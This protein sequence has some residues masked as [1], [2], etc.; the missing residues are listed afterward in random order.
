M[1]ANHSDATAIFALPA[2]GASGTRNPSATANTIAETIEDQN[3][4]D[5]T[6][7]E[8]DE[9]PDR[10]DA[11]DVLTVLRFVLDDVYVAD[12]RCADMLSRRR[13]PETT[14]A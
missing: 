9:V 4:S 14:G 12:A 2:A 1:E 10:H 11:K 8:I 13:P 6:H 3:H 5:I 7:G